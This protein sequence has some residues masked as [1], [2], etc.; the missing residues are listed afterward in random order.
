MITD[1]PT[2][3]DR[4]TGL[5]PKGSSAGFTVVAFYWLIYPSL[6]CVALIPLGR[7]VFDFLFPAMA[8]PV[9]ALAVI[10]PMTFGFRSRRYWGV[11]LFRWA[12]VAAICFVVFGIL[13][14]AGILLATS[15]APPPLVGLTWAAG[16]LMLLLAGFLPFVLHLLRLSYWNP[17]ATEIDWEQGGERINPRV[18]RALGRRR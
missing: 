2:T 17:N 13:L 1:S 8:S 7:T 18:A 4:P 10:L 16:A 3:R 12:T 9:V 15:R 11:R 14:V 5:A 6:L